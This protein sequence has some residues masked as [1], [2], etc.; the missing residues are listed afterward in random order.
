[1]T[2]QEFLAM[3][4][5]YELHGITA[6]RIAL[7]NGVEYEKELPI[8]WRGEKFSGRCGFGIMP[9]L[10]PLSDLTKWIEHKGEKIIPLLELKWNRTING[11]TKSNIEAAMSTL[12]F[13][14]A[15][16]LIEWH[17]DLFGYIDNGEAIDVNTL[18]ENP[19]K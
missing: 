17:F 13:K 7:I 10:H 2:K 11:F 8:I 6:N 14:D 12:S 1:M 9:I 5:P 18:R 3:S 19:Y 4:L 16:K 15:L